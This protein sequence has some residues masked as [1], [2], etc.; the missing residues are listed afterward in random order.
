MMPES[1]GV[2]SFASFAMRITL[3]WPDAWRWIVEP[4][5]LPIRRRARR[6]RRRAAFLRRQ[7]LQSVGQSVRLPVCQFRRA[8]PGLP[9][10]GHRARPAPAARRACR[11]RSPPSPCWRS[12]WAMARRCR[13]WR[14]RSPRCSSAP[15]PGC[16]GRRVRRARAGLE[17]S[18]SRPR[19]CFGRRP[20]SGL[21]SCRRG[22]RAR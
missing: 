21:A 18:L 5:R 2:F 9:R 7:F 22:T 6:H 3:T 12:C 8:Q 13:C 4:R 11:M 1:G 19:R 17:R 15:P 16:C 14:I 20:H 10:L